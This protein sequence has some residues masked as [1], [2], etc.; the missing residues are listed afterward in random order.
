MGQAG[1]GPIPEQIL[2]AHPA[3]R[4]AD[5]FFSQQLAPDARVYEKIVPL[6]VEQLQTAV[7]LLM[8]FGKHEALGLRGVQ[9]EVAVARQGAIPS[10]G[11]ERVTAKI[12]FTAPGS[13]I[14]P[15][16]R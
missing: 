3:Q 8:G 4:I 12:V 10:V 11:Q 6:E 7:E 14:F 13:S 15:P 1:A 2:G 16:A 9:V 5:L